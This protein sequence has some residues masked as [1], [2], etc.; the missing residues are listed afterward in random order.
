MHFTF[1]QSD[2]QV[3]VGNNMEEVHHTPDYMLFIFQFRYAVAKSTMI[4][5]LLNLR[6]STLDL[7]TKA[8][9]WLEVESLGEL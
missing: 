2:C 7:A 6:A 8:P 3:L 4:C 1:Y 9:Q 5:Y